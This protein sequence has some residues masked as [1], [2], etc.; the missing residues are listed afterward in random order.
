M[1]G[2]HRGSDHRVRPRA[3]Q[4]GLA[5]G[6]RGRLRRDRTGAVSSAIRFGKLG[7]IGERSRTSYKEQ[8]VEE[9]PALL[10]RRR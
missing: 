10:P 1:S 2:Y 5:A 6:Q 3:R 4:L 8:Y 7:V 9:E